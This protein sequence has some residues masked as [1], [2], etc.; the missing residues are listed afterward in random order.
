MNEKEMFEKIKN[1]A[2]KIEVPE[3][4]SPERMRGKLPERPV[5]FPAKKKK[6]VMKYLIPIATAAAAFAVVMV[7]VGPALFQK[8]NAN[9]S[10]KNGST[11]AAG[12]SSAENQKGTAASESKTFTRSDA[13]TAYRVAKSD[14]EIKEY[15]KKLDEERAGDLKYTGGLAIAENADSNV[16]G[17]PIA[18]AGSA[19]QPLLIPI[20]TSWRK[21]STKA[22]S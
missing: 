12:A 13:G 14:N 18:A 10:A 5:S 3:S 1:E 21:A 6:G 19:P 8:N 4:L 9:S 11:I 20:R 2:E 7:A 16:S 17:A 15:I 22:I